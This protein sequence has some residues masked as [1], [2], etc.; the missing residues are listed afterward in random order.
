MGGQG[1]GLLSP[2]HHSVK[3]PG[4]RPGLSHLCKVSSAGTNSPAV[5]SSPLGCQATSLFRGAG[6]GA[7]N[8]VSCSFAC[9]TRSARGRCTGRGRGVLDLTLLLLRVSLKLAA[10][11]VGPRS[12]GVAA[13]PHR[14]SPGLWGLR[15]WALELRGSRIPPS[16]V[17]CCPSPCGLL[18]LSAPPAS[19]PGTRMFSV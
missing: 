15:S 2:A 9:S 16:L 1:Q 19:I 3:A 10:S 18:P 12:L 14:T 6:P 8:R 7:P 4:P 11:L 17:D 13:P 5:L